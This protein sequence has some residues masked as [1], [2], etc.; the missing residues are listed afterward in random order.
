MQALNSDT[1]FSLVSEIALWTAQISV[2]ATLAIFIFILISRALYK[3]RQKRKGGLI[4]AMRPILAEVALGEKEGNLATLPVHSK[5][6]GNLFLH[7]W[8]VVQESLTGNSSSRLN[9]L[10]RRLHLDSLARALL[11]HRQ[12]R[13]RLLAA[14]TLGHM[15]DRQAWRPLLTTLDSKNSLVSQV[16]ARALCQIDPGRGAQELVKRIP[17]RHDWPAGRVATILA[18]TGQEYVEKPLYAALA[19]ATPKQAISLLKFVPLFSVSRRDAPI[20]D[21]LEGATDPAL[22]A[23]CLKVLRDPSQLPLVR[24]LTAHKTWYVRV[25]AITFLGQ[26]GVAQDADIITRALTDSEWWV[27]YRAAQALYEMPW[28]DVPKLRSIQEKQVDQFARDILDQVIS[29]ASFA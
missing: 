14:A 6:I 7:Q 18:E 13:M 21:I 11:D 1:S 28:I 9:K 10:A 25:H 17:D 26:A 19:A 22:I 12:L 20:R 5:R 27:R 24:K 3:F 16:S 4:K 29:E 2:L 23:A 15:R 8:N